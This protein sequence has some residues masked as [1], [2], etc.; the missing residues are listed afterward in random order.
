MVTYL[1]ACVRPRGSGRRRGWGVPEPT[2]W[3]RR[4]SEHD[5]GSRRSPA[6]AGIA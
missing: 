2:G 5:R 4:Q 1:A 6:V 3:A